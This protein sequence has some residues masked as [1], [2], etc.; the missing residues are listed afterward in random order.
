[1]SQGASRCITMGEA[2]RMPIRKRRF[3]WSA[4]DLRTLR[5]RTHMRMEGAV[6]GGKARW[7]SMRG[8]ACASGPRSGIACCGRSGRHMKTSRTSRAAASPKRVLIAAITLTNSKCI[9][10]GRACFPARWAIVA[11]IDAVVARA[12]EAVRAGV[13]RA[14]AVDRRRPVH[15]EGETMEESR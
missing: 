12:E 3:T 14:G 11:K 2:A 4:N 13:G 9:G 15:N 10:G 1:M 8:V 5:W 6:S 7:T